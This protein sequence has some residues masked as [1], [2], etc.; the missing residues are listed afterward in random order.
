MIDDWAGREESINRKSAIANRK[1]PDAEVTVTPNGTV[2]N[3]LPLDH[4]KIKTRPAKG[5]I[6]FQDH[7]LPLSQRKLRI[8]EL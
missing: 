5:F 1:S 7:A 3:E 4:E 2:V 6:G 8:R